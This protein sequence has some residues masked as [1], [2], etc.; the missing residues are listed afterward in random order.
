VGVRAGGTQATRSDDLLRRTR[1]GTASVRELRLRVS[2][3]EITNAQYAEFLNAK[4]ASDP[5]GLYNAS[6]GSDATFG[7]ITRSGVSGSYTYTAKAGFANKPVTYV[8]FYNSLRFSNWLNTGRGSATQ[9]RAHTQSWRPLV[10]ST[11]PA[12]A[13]PTSS[14]PANEW[15][16]A[17][18]Y[19]PGSVYFDFD[20]DGCVT[21]CVAP[22]SD[23][24]NSAT[25]ISVNAFTTSGLRS[26][27]QPLRHV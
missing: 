5:L 27:G 21:D 3:H 15:Y 26:I 8:S 9:R 24:G 14:S 10:N 16:K 1:G 7:G 11:R 6:M 17:A 19:S 22:G 2:R 18:Y 12:P 4:A 25:A 13:A 20:G 23:T